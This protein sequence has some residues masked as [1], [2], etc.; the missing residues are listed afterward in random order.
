MRQNL[1]MGFS[2]ILGSWRCITL[3]SWIVTTSGRPPITRARS[4]RKIKQSVSLLVYQRV[5]RRNFTL[6][7]LSVIT[8]S[9]TRSEVTAQT[10]RSK[11]SR[12]IQKG[13]A[14]FTTSLLY[15]IYESYTS[16]QGRQLEIAST[17]FQNKLSSGKNT[18]VTAETITYFS[19]RQLQP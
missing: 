13:D 7:T 18:K 11:H 2:G 15:S 14:S 12:D 17:R 4:T 10:I 8:F 3:P 19:L 1:I 16:S 6:L 9:K 5:L